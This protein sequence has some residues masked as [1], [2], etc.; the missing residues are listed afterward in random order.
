MMPS[1]LPER[2]L[3]LL[4]QLRKLLYDWGGSGSFRPAQGAS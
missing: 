3:Q 1:P 2:A 4:F